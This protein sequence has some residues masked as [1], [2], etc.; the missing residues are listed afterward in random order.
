MDDKGYEDRIYD[1]ASG[2]NLRVSIEPFG[3]LGQRLS[4]VRDLILLRLWHL[5]VSLPFVLEARV[6]SYEGQLDYMLF[7]RNG[8]TNRNL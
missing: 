5:C 8:S 4:T 1:C 3:Q 2:R 6:P 7:I